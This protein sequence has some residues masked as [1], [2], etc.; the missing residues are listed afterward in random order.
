MMVNFETVMEYYKKIFTSKTVQQTMLVIGG[1]SVSAIIGALFFIF[2]A[3]LLGPSEFGIFSFGTTLLVLMSDIFDFG[4]NGGIIRFVSESLSQNDHQRAM[5]ALKLSFKIKISSALI[6]I[7]SGFLLSPWIAKTFLNDSSQT[8]FIFLI[9]VATL[10]SL[11][12]DFV[13][14][15]LQSYQKFGNFVVVIVTSNIVRLIF[16]FGAVYF[17]HPLLGALGSLMAGLIFAIVIGL[18]QVKLNFLKAHGEKLLIGE[19]YKFNRW[20]AV[21]FIAAAISSR[22]DVFFLAKQSSLVE[23]GFY[24]FASKLA[25]IFPQIAGGLSTVLGPKFSRFHEAGSAQQFLRRCLWI[26]TGLGAII[27]TIVFFSYFLLFPL[28]YPLYLPSLPIFQLI[29]IGMVF[30]ILQVGPTS[31][32]TYYLSKPHINTLF[33]LLQLVLVLFLN[34]LLI[35]VWGAR[36]AA[37]TFIYSQGFIFFA[38]LIASITL[39]RNYI[40]SKL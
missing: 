40:K 37:T 18:R 2:S 23:L 20:I 24:G 32:I 36:G 6:L 34:G 12:F 13:S 8:L 30:L 35:P 10:P 11:L 21:A 25:F 4:T 38:S 28:F 3:R 16:L 39:S 9:F 5:Q 7:V 15:A 19:I 26:T 27:L 22:L 1:T 33:S 14:F 17:L 31:Y 29:L